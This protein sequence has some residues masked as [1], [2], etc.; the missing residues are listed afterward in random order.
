VVLAHQPLE[1]SE[2]TQQI[3]AFLPACLLLGTTV[4]WE[5]ASSTSDRDAAFQYVCSRRQ[6]VCVAAWQVAGVDELFYFYNFFVYT[7]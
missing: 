2:Q 5:R 1:S 6:A 4:R 7:N 3:D